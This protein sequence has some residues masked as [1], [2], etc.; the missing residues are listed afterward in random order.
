[1]ATGS[2]WQYVLLATCTDESIK[3]LGKDLYLSKEEVA[4]IVVILDLVICFVFWFGLLAM[5]PLQEAIKTEASV[6]TITPEDF[7]V[8]IKQVPYLDKYEEL[9]PVY[10][11][12]AEN[13]LE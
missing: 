1:M 10:W 8:V 7:T 5:N 9:R 6:T 12:W 4:A 3:V 2:N 13:I 11:A